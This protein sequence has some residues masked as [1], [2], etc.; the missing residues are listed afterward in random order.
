MR[1]REPGE[2]RVRLDERRRGYD[3]CLAGLEPS[4]ELTRRPLVVLVPGAQGGHHAAGIGEEPRGHR[5]RP[6]LA[7]ALESLACLLDRLG[8]QPFDLV[9]GDRD[10]ESTLADQPNGEGRGLDLDPSIVEANLHGR[11]RFEPSERSD[12]LRDH[13]AASGVNGSFHGIDCT[14]LH[15]IGGLVTIPQLKPRTG[16]GRYGSSS[17]RISPSVSFTDKAATASS[18]W[19]GLLAPMIGA[20]TYGLQSIQASAT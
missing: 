17:R 19:C 16:C 7:P 4:F 8:G 3:E 10:D 13:Q 20:V 6:R 2:D 9:L 5:L 15:L 12:L 14:M 18:R 11:P 1:W